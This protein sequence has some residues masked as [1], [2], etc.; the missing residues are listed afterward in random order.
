METRLRILHLEDSP[1]DAEL[2]QMALAQ[3]G[4][5]HN[6]KAVAT[7]EDF[8]A[9]LAEPPFDVILSDSDVRGFDGAT[10]LTLVREQHRQIPFFFVPGSM[11]TDARVKELKESG[12][13]DIISKWEL[14]SLVNSILEAIHGRE[15]IGIGL[16]KSGTI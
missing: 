14:K 2:V 15:R 7:K 5:P 13:T 6:V 3:A 9:A 4:I 16:R 11:P 1:E 10:A 8:I 12:A